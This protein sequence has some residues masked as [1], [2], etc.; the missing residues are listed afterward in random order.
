MYGILLTM[1]KTCLIAVCALLICSITWVVCQ[2]RDEPC[3]KATAQD[4]PHSSSYPEAMWEVATQGQ[5]LQLFRASPLPDTHKL[6]WQNGKNAPSLGD[7]NARR[8]GVLRTNNVGPFPAH[9]L[10]F[11]SPVPQFFHYNLFD[12]INIPLVRQHPITGQIL[13]ALAE[14]WAEDGRTIHFRLNKR[15]RYSNGAPLRA[16][17]FALGTWLRKKAGRDGA[18]PKINNLIERIDIRGTHELSVTMRKIRPL[19]PLLIAS[20]LHPAEPGFYSEFSS[21]YATRYAQ[22]IP[23]TTGAYIVKKLQRGRLIRLE[24]V[25]NWWGDKVPA[26]QHSY[27]VDAIE[28]HFLTDEAQAWELLRKGHLNFLQT[29]F[30]SGWLQRRDE[31]A[32]NADICFSRVEINQPLPPYG[33]AINAK[34][35]PNPDLRRGIKHALNMQHAVEQVFCGEYEC[36]GSFTSGYPWL[37]SNKCTQT[38]N[39]SPEKAR[40]A[41]A[42]AGYIRQGPDGILQKDDGTRL[43]VSLLYPPSGRNTA[44]MNHLVQHARTCGLELHTES[45]AWQYAIRRIN[46]QSHQLIFWATVPSIPLPDYSLHFSPDIHK[47]DTPF[48]FHNQ[49]LKNL[50]Q[51]YEACSNM[52]EIAQLCHEIDAEIANACIWIPAWKENRAFTAHSAKVKLPSNQGIISTCDVAD[53]HLLWIEQ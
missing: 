32:E 14:A 27:N 38:N 37:Q 39:F 11:G 9:F 21:D 8:G 4:S 15:A 40:L 53:S 2:Q 47:H 29:R 36:L 33:I 26:F 18:W 41:F 44:F 16:A 10:A 45:V 19:A 1:K 12:C 35:L 17:D 30:V 49:Q 51:R 3:H 43:C 24:R 50:L 31:W 42:A 48:A 46:E 5:E 23:P 13:P 52:A 20:V 25:P 28:H 6:H 7:S 34:T 22:R